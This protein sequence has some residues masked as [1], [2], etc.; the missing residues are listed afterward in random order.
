MKDVH[1]PGLASDKPPSGL[2]VAE[3][4]GTGADDC[5]GSPSEEELAWSISF[6]GFG[7]SGTPIANRNPPCADDGVRAGFRTVSKEM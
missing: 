3:P 4:G 5:R 7:C 2:T 1:H 6:A